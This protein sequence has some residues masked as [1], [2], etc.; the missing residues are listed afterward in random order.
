MAHRAETIIAAVAALL[1]GLIT[2]ESRVYRGRAYAFRPED[3]PGL[4]VYQGVDRVVE[5]LSH[6]VLICELDVN[7]DAVAIDPADTADETLIAI[8]AEATVALAADY[9]LGLAFVEDFQELGA[10][11][12]AEEGIGEAVAA[13]QRLQ[14]RATY[15]RSRTD[16]GA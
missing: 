2:T 7:I 5:V 6:D 16:P 13:R 12:P 1:D 14:W 11:E 4:A 10:G 8:R 3:V 15:R 9:T